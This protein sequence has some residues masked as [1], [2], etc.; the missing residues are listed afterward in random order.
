MIRKLGEKSDKNLIWDYFLRFRKEKHQS[1]PIDKNENKT[2]F[3][4]ILQVFSHREAAFVIPI[5]LLL[6][7]W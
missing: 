6:E 2:S 1:N 7:D 5:D 4:N 3:L